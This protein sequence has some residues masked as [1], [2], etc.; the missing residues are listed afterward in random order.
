MMSQTERA[1]LIVTGTIFLI[2]PLFAPLW[3]EA[4]MTDN[5]LLMA[6]IIPIGFGFFFFCLAV[7]I[8]GVW[9]DGL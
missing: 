1:L 4:L 8:I 3:A 6:Q 2:V 7:L 9:L 5:Q